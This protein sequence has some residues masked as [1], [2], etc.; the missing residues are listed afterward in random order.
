MAKPALLESASQRGRDRRDP[1][2]PEP[3][4]DAMRR[5]NEWLR[6]S[7]KLEHRCGRRSGMMPQGY[8]IVPATR[9]S[10]GGPSRLDRS[11]PI[12]RG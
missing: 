9:E 1:L 8:E 5:L 11:R 3:L 6:R 10:R 12:A 7:A 4:R 2:R